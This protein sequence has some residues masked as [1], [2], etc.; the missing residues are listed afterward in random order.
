MTRKRS[1]SAVSTDYMKERGYHVEVVERFIPGAM[2]RK[3]FCGVGDLI[4][5][6]A[7]RKLLLVQTTSKANLSS[8]VKKVTVSEMLPLLLEHF[9][10]EIHGISPDGTVYVHRIL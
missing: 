10:I 5:I 4:G 8:R 6:K 1:P 9:D 2:I 3:D 7:S